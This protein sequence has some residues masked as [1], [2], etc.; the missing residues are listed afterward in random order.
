MPRRSR[1]EPEG[2]DSFGEYVGLTFTKWDK[3]YSQC[4]VEVDGRLLNP[5]RSLHGGVAFTMAD[6]GM[7][8]ALLSML[9]EGERCATVEC[10]I[11]YFRAVKSGT[12]TC[13]T[14]VIHKSKRIAAL[15]SEI[16]QGGLLLAKAMGTWSI[17]QER[18]AA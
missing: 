16:R 17:Y 8:F 4:T 12:L 18:R 5:Y 10:S 1:A 3:G 7:G 2:F 13:D 6:S 14:R 15:E 9:E 11:V